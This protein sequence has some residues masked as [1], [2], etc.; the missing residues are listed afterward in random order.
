MPLS[1]G[2]NWNDLTQGKK[3][4]ASQVLE[5]MAWG[6]EGHLFPHFSGTTADNTYDLGGATEQW[7]TGYFGTGL[8]SPNINP[9]TSAGGV[10]IGQASAN[11]NTCFDMSA[12]PK[13][14]YLPIL[15]TT[16]RNNLTPSAGFILYNSTNSRMERYE[17][18]Q[19][20]AMNN[21]IGLKAKAPITHIQGA[22]QTVADLTGSGRILSLKSWF[23]TAGTTHLKIV[24]DSDV[25][26]LN[27]SPLTGTRNLF[28][29]PSLG[30]TSTTFEFTTSVEKLDI[31][32]KES[33][34]V[35]VWRTGGTVGTAYMLYELS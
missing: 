21:P 32:F 26:D 19:W 28:V 25:Y 22:T 8:Y 1:T 18:G 4:K 17:G 16:E 7:R 34:Q 10:A 5:N 35:Y 3:A 20:L 12:F 33:L 13:A 15:T 29:V 31:Q 27:P 6:G 24:L 11:A 23:E 14:M 30:D 9:S 2:A